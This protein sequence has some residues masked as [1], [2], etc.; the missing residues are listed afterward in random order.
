[1]NVKRSA[2]VSVNARHFCDFELNYTKYQKSLQIKCT[3][4][5]GTD[6]RKRELNKN[7]SKL[8]LV[9]YYQIRMEVSFY[10]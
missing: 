5:S 9:Q 8:D 7:T 1:M 3:H 6:P 4:N 10:G 2:D